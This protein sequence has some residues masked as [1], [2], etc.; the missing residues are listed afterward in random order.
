MDPRQQTLG[1]DTVGNKTIILKKTKGSLKNYLKYFERIDFKV[2]E[3]VEVTDRWHRQLMVIS[4][5][6]QGSTSSIPTTAVF[7]TMANYCC[8]LITRVS[9]SD[10]VIFSTV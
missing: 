9:A 7:G 4:P 2:T 8:I 10:C 5:V 1:D 6:I 3:L